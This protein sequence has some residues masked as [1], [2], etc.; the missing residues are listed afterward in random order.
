MP[1]HLI[2]ESDIPLEAQCDGLPKNDFPMK[3]VTTYWDLSNDPGDQYKL[4]SEGFPII[5]YFS[6]IIDSI[7]GKEMDKAKLD[8][9]DWKD[10]TTFYMSMR[11]YI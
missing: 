6:S 7:T 8:T 5:P 9:G 3:G 10:S 4:K 2:F 11:M 1:R